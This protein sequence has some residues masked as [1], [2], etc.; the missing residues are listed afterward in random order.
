MAKVQVAVG[1]GKGAGDENFT[2]LGHSSYSVRMLIFKG[3]HYSI[4][5]GIRLQMRV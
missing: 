4:L 2:G 3:A 5:Q 1:I